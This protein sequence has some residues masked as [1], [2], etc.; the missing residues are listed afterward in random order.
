MQTLGDIGIG[1]HARII[2]FN[3]SKP[4][5][6]AKLLSMGLT[7]GTELSVENIA[8]MGDPILIQLRGFY[9]SLRADEASALQ[10][11]SIGSGAEGRPG[12]GRR[13]MGGGRRHAGGRRAGGRGRGT[14]TG[15][16]R[17]FGFGFG[18]GFGRRRRHDADLNAG[19][20]GEG[21]DTPD[22]GGE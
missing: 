20:A 13:G 19:S 8:P 6:R 15:R 14:D 5:Y 3:P 18:M 2:G 1:G 9:L 16:G 17:G 11:E 10:L 22:H 21:G 7:R 12:T 4:G